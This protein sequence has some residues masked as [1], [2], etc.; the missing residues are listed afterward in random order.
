MVFFIVILVVFRQV[1]FN[2]RVPFSANLLVSLFQPWFSDFG[3]SVPN[4]AIGWDNVKIFFP[5]RVFTQKML[6]DLKIPFWNPFNFSGNVHLA[7]SQTAIFYPLNVVYFLLSGINGWTVLTIVGFLAGG[8]FTYLFVNQLVDDKRAALLSGVSFIFSG[9]AI[10][11][12]EDGLVIFHSFLWLPL[13]L[14]GFELFFS[15]RKKKYLLLSLFGIASSI[16][17]GWFQFTFYTL[18]LAFA[19]LTYKALTADWFKAKKT[20]FIWLGIVW[21]LGIGLTS[22]H[23]LPA[24]RALFLSPRGTKAPMYFIDTFLLGE[25]GL[26][27]LLAPDFFGNPTT[28][29]YFGESFYKEKVLF[30]SIVPLFLAVFQFLHN[31]FKNKRISFFSAVTMICFVLGFR[32]PLSSA[33]IKSGIPVISSFVPSR[34]FIVSAFSLSVVAGFG[35]KTMLKSFFKKEQV[36]WPALIL[37]VA[38][39]AVLF[40]GIFSLVDRGIEFNIL[41]GYKRLSGKNLQVAFRNSLLP[42]GSFIGLVGILGLGFV[43]PKWLKKWVWVP[44]LLIPTLFGVYYANKYLF[45]GERQFV[46]PSHPVWE[47]LSELSQDKF[48]YWSFGKG[49][50]ESN[51]N[52]YYQ[53]YSPEGVDAMY[54]RWYAQLM[55]GC[56]SKGEFPEEVMRIEAEICGADNDYQP[57]NHYQQRLLDLTGVKYLVRVGQEDEIEGAARIW[58]DGDWEIWERKN[59]LPRAY[60]VS[61]YRVADSE[62]ESLEAVYSQEFNP[63]NEAV[64]LQEPAI[65]KEQSLLQ[66]AELKE[67]TA[68]KVVVATKAEQDSLLMLSDTYYPEWKARVDGEEAEVLRANHAFRAVVVPEGSHQ[69]VFYYSGSVFKKGIIISIFSLLGLV[70]IFKKKELLNEQ[71]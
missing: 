22:F 6:T 14:Y 23:F 3:S 11:R 67:Y 56:R 47:K 66:K 27:T 16:F 36:S 1:F 53:V 33:V 52:T 34:I 63:H 57:E 4:K 12:I 30:V 21:I 24:A 54:P 10:V 60:L 49:H 46:F 51:F 58:Q 15:R 25:E 71:D 69:V 7:N 42:L 37:T 5:Q 38:L 35:L 61:D 59:V 62:N 9:P 8:V 19:Y 70:F 39:F 26:I 65:K 31:L 20:N 29:N 18:G 43:L 68:N 44:I 2:N 55:E 64:L 32:N 28:Y 13:I 50:I 41:R 40:T 48:R 17:A 45:F